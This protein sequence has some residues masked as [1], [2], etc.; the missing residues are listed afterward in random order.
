MP[1]DLRQL[2]PLC[3]VYPKALGDQ[4]LALWT[5]VAVE[6]DPRAADLLV[7]LEGDVAADHVVQE[8]AQAPDSGLVAVVLVALDP[9]GRGIHTRTCMEQKEK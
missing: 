7:R 6:A 9:L 2:D 5:D 3:R 8:D 4:V 1:Y